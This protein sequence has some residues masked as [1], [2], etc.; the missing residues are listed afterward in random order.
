MATYKESG[1]DIEAGDELVER[2]KK[3]LPHLGG[4]A[5]LYPL[6][7]SYLVAGTDGV[8]T[9]LK[10]AI[11]NGQHA[12]V[13]IDLVAMCVNDILT[14]GA[15]PLFFL[16]YYASSKLNVEQAEEVIQGIIKGCDEAEC[17]LL[18]GE[19]AEMPG[20]YQ[21]GEYDIA[22]FAVGI[23]AKEALIDGSRI[24]HGDALVGLYSSGLH[25]NGFSLVRKILGNDASLLTPTRIYVNA[26]QRIRKRYA[27]KGMAH[28]TGG[29]LTENVPRMFPPGL[30]ACIDRES[31][32]VPEVFRR[33]QKI[34]CI[35]DDEMYLTFNMGIGMVLAM[36]PRD[37][38]ALCGERDDCTVIGEVISGDTITWA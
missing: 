25:S 16:D 1:V 14:T 21:E 11:A 18:G 10:I 7:D 5:G 24:A 2:L 20:F 38:K 37:A 4:F 3:R 33:I 31:W 36:D 32:E 8:G 6:G 28:I 17:V 9:K 23:V 26:V 15:R 22:G 29:G 27:I 13:G 19:T 34:G 35:S 12:T 30:A